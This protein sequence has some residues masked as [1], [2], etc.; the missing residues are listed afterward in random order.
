MTIRHLLVAGAALAALSVAA[1]QPKNNTAT[2]NTTANA[3]S[4][5]PVATSDSMAA[6]GASSAPTADATAASSAADASSAAAKK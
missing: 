1:C 5:A 2:D 6:T 3:E 4:A